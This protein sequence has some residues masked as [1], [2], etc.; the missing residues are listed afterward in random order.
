MDLDFGTR[1]RTSFVLFICAFVL[2][3][4]ILPNLN[5]SLMSTF[6]Y[7]DPIIHSA[8]TSLILPFHLD[9]LTSLFTTIVLQRT[10][11]VYRLLPHTLFSGVTETSPFLLAR[12]IGTKTDAWL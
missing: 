10:L 7:T 9:L 8:L 1:T 2:S 6:F 11:T 4:H 5:P 3:S 12:V